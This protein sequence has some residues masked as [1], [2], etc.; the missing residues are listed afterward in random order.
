MLCRRRHNLPEQGNRHRERVTAPTD[1]RQAK[2]EHHVV[3]S[4]VYHA[5]TTQM[6]LKTKQNQAKLFFTA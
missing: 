5:I 4:V 3:F 1:G 2:M 6:F